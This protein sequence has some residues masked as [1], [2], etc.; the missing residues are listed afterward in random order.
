VLKEEN[1]VLDFFRHASLGQTVLE[2]QGDFIIDETETKNPACPER[3]CGLVHKLKI[4]PKRRKVN[5]G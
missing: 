5:N 2:L 4:T 3:S 1:G